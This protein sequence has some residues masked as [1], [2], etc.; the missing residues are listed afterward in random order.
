M[1]QAKT[2]IIARLQREVIGLQGFNL[3]ENVVVN[4]KLGPIASAL[5]GG[6]FPLGAVHEFLCEGYETAASTIGFL[7]GLISSVIENKGAIVW[8]SASRFVFPPGLSGYGIEPDRFI[9]IDLNKSKDILW[10]MEEALKCSAVRAVVGELTDLNFTTSRRLQLAVE[11]SKVTGFVLR[12]RNPGTTACVSRWR[13]TPLPSHTVE[14]IPGI[15]VPQWRVELLRIRNG[16]PGAWDIRW[17]DSRF[18]SAAV[19]ETKADSID[20]R[21]EPA[22]IRSKTG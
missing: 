21:T 4:E 18:I 22:Y 11:Q 9:F 19:E 14:N 3:S 12:S 20:Q 10:T 7:G 16:R 1:R 6:T 8:A 13:V 5:P 15:G 17:E 2:D